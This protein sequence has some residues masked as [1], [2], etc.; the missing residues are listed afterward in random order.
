MV[1]VG[2]M[3]TCVG[4]QLLVEFVDGRLD[5]QAAARVEDHVD[6]CSSC[7]ERLARL[8]RQDGDVEGEPWPAF[9]EGR[10]ELH[11]EHGRGGIGMVLRAH[12]R[13]LGR[14][15]AL[16]LLV[17]PT[18]AARARFAREA[19][20]TARLQH[21]SIVTIHDV[22]RHASGKPGYTM[23]LYPG[24]SLR[25]AIGAYPT[26][27][28][29]MGLIRHALAVTEA[30][31][32]AHARGV[33]HRDLKPSN[34]LLGELGETVVIDWGLARS[35]GDPD[36]IAAASGDDDSALATR[37]G[38]VLGTPSYMPPEQARGERVD[39]RADVYALGALL[40]HL[41]AG[42]PPFD[43]PSSPAVLQRVLAERPPDVRAVERRCPEDLA[44]LVRKAMT[45]E[46]AGRYPEAGALADDL[47]RWIDG[48]LVRAHEYG[49]A[50]LLWRF[51][52]RHRALV[53][54]ALLVTIVLGVSAH[55]I[56][57]ERDAA[58]ASTARLIL[59]QARARLDSDPTA[60]LAWLK[61]YPSWGVAWTEVQ[62][63]ASDASSRG[64]ARHVWIADEDVVAALYSPAN[65]FVA[66]ASGAEVQIHDAAS[67]RLTARFAQEGTRCLSYSADGHVLLAGSET[68]E[69]M[70]V[71]PAS[72]RVLGRV[73]A[74]HQGWITQLVTAPDQAHVVSVGVDGVIRTW[75]LSA[76]GI[77][78][79]PERELRGHDGI[80][81]V[82][83]FDR[84]G[85]LWSSGR[86]GTV[87]RWDLDS[88]AAEM[89]LALGAT[90]PYAPLAVAD[91][92][93]TFVTVDHDR[94]LM[95]SDGA[96]RELG[97]LPAAQR[98]VALRPDGELAASAGDDGTVTWWSA[99]GQL[100]SDP[101]HSR[102][103]VALALSTDGSTLAA[104]DVEGTIRVWQDGQLR[105]LSGHTAK[106]ASLVFS[107]DGRSLL[108]ASD[109]GT[110]R[111]WMLD[112]RGR[113]VRVSPLPLFRV[114]FAAADHELVT[115]SKDGAVRTIELASGE[116]RELG[117]QPRAAYDLE[118][119]PGRQAAVA[120]FWDGTLGR[121]DLVGAEPAR[122]WQHGARIW[123]LDVAHDGRHAVSAGDDGA[124]RLWDLNAPAGR[125]ITS[126]PGGAFDAT[127]SADG[128]EVASSGADEII[129]VDDL[130]SGSETRLRGHV[131]TVPVLL[132]A[133]DG[134]TL[135]SGGFDGTVRGWDLGQGRG[136]VIDRHRKLV[137]A[138]ALSPDGRWLASGSRDQEIHLVDLRSGR[139]N[140]TFSGHGAE[141]RHVAFS[142]DGQWL[143]SAGWD[144]T[145]RLWHVPDGRVLVLR[146]HAGPV[147]R[148]AFSTDGRWLA[149][150][151][152][153]GSVGL[154]KLA[155]ADP[156][157][158][159]S[160]E[161]RAW[162][163]G[164][165]SATIVAD[166]PTPATITPR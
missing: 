57:A 98:V 149:S 27:Q 7:F 25:E 100:R 101:G 74:A 142:P 21:P 154:W 55:R 152:D 151:S 148:V 146:G 150:A 8:A 6:G 42:K 68:G 63:I 75:R 157:P 90:R 160:D 129:D 153:D 24:R 20:I 139:A 155:D 70:A 93:E 110:I 156:L 38:A 34:V 73:P 161:L 53:A 159:R 47:R 71:D 22:G 119:L 133:A 43:G 17:D 122:T 10:Y 92:G 140:A 82:V 4:E 91:D 120:A 88:G 143:A 14:V 165:T 41:V 18:P 62:A 77:D 69:I 83:S 103:V 37:T 102:P 65:R 19:T 115:T 15:V 30:M 158:V 135:F 23:P 96:L 166:G 64:V 97:R 44:T 126:H 104:G 50:Q 106:V 66:S 127:F 164:T 59:T 107:S 72:R 108:S 28:G 5:A 54:A 11:G 109:D 36:E 2:S 125:V 113:F 35:A 138:L 136:K 45:P 39:A 9:E 128:Q 61:R 40:Y 134:K 112:R 117:R 147:H 163:E 26:F 79:V 46:P 12:D 130:R 31:A 121:F 105:V 60:A 81:D 33:L 32:H 114:A 49:R 48:G 137:A 99:T 76:R 58:R 141:V 162:L 89:R 95:H 78:A 124:V 111:L 132:F 29:R 84:K 1:H 80:I 87:R 56:V 94:L 131:G 145:V 123:G 16:K 116:L 118:L 13:R 52:R 51:V 85:R 67:G 144:A 3:S 86:D